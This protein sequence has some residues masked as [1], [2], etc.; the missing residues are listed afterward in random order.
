MKPLSL[1]G[2]LATVSFGCAGQNGVEPREQSDGA[3]AG[4]APTAGAAGFTPSSML[5]S[6]NIHPNSTG[7]KFMADHWYGVIGP[8]LPQ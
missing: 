7:Y 6:D 3:T 4:N 2:L 1:A 5:G 8:L